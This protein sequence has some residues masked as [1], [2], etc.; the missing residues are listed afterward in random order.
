L[1]QIDE[2][3]FTDLLASNMGL[4]ELEYT[5]MIKFFTEEDKTLKGNY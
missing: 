4:A 5:P 1:Y 2:A 3:F